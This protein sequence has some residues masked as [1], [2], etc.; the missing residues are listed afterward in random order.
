MSFRKTLFWMHLTAGIFA[1]TVILIMSV[2]G[3]MLAFQRQITNFADHRL[4]SPV[5]VAPVSTPLPIEDL[6]QR[7]SSQVHSKPAAV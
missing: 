7:A 6:L 4:L 5:N 1:G 3:V 2:T